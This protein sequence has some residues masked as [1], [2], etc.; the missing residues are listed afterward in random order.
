MSEQYKNEK[1]EPTESF[2]KFKELT[3][4]LLS[5]SNK[6]AREQESANNREQKGGAKQDE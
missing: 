5:V 4:T 2:Q 6:E 1:N 3:K